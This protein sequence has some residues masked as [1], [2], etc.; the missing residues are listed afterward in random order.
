[1]KR[2]FVS[3]QLPVPRH[4]FD[5]QELVGIREQLKSEYAEIMGQLKDATR[6]MERDNIKECV[7]KARE[8]LGKKRFTV[9]HALGKGGVRGALEVL[10]QVVPVGIRLSM[11]ATEARM[12]LESRGQRELAERVQAASASEDLC[13]LVARDLGEVPDILASAADCVCDT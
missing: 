3:M 6:Q 2:A 8:E 10:E 13:D 11:P 5:A 4:P 1:M 7:E 9:Q 12:V